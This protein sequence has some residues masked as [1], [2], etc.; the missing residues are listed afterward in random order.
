M[1]FLFGRFR[2]VLFLIVLVVL[3]VSIATAQSITGTVEDSTGAVVPG[4]KVEIRNPVSGLVRNTTSDNT[5]SYSIPNL[6]LNPYHLTVTAT[7]FASFVQDVEVRSSVPVF[8]IPKLKLEAAQQVVDVNGEAADL[9]ENTST[10]HTDV[11]RA[12]FDKVPLESPSSSVSSLVTLTTPGIAADSNGLFHGMG[13]HAENSFSVDGQPITDQQSKV[14]SNQIPLDSIQSLEVISGAPPA[15]FGDKTSVVINVTTRSGQGLTTPKGSITTSYGSFG[16]ADLALNLGY[17]G[18]KWGNFISASGLNSGRFL[19][20]PEFAV[21][22]DKGNEE[23]LFD[24]VDFQVSP[25]DSV[26]V[27]LGFTR[28]WFQTPN[29]FD[30]LNVTD[31]NGDSVGSTDQ[32]SQIKTFNIA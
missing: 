20:P 5:G 26:H 32:R 8:V 17:G 11:D 10:F 21:I 6:P 29:A 12:L 2:H 25:S 24:R 1:S 9:I 15:E 16:T 27:N 23:N 22:H 3:A 31:Q 13:D 19:D 30:N 14:F 28:S 7:V 18:Q 4:A